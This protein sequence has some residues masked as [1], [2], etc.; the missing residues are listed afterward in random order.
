MKKCCFGSRRIV[1]SFAAQGAVF[2]VASAMAASAMAAT[3]VA[4]VKD[5][6]GNSVPNA[7]VYAV[8]VGTPARAA[9]VGASAQ[10]EQTGFKYEPF[11]S[12][13]QKGTQMRFPNRDKADHHVKVLSGPQLFEFQIYTKKEPAAVVLDKPGLITLQCLL[14]NWM[15]AHIYVVDTP[16]FTKTTK[17]GPGL[18]QELP[19]GEYDVFVT[20][21]SVLFPG[22]VSPQMPRR[23][24][25]ESTG[26]QTIDVKFDFVPKPEP[27]R[28][29]P[30]EY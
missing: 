12:V 15:N 27:S 29:T 23:V 9:N 1:A 7:V 10:V 11:V 25:L 14:H 8:P 20:H 4:Q 17:T 13:V 22:Q 28:R 21:P 26:S 3:I 6:N 16:Y 2:F 5:K 19:A 24:K 30:L 18:L